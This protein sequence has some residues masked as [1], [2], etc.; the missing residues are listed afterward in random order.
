MK[1]KSSSLNSKNKKF[2][3]TVEYENELE[4]LKDVLKEKTLELKKIQIP[5]NIQFEIKNYKRV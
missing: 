1:R 2:K 3:A 4:Y 5:P